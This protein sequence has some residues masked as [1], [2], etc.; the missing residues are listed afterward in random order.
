MQYMDKGPL[1]YFSNY[2]GAM[3]AD[4]NGNPRSSPNIDTDYRIGHT[5]TLEK[6]IYYPVTDGKPMAETELHRDVLIEALQTLFEYYKDAPDVCVSGNMMM[7]Y[8]KGEPRKSISPDVFVTFGIEKKLRRIY[9][10]WEEGKPPDFVI[11]FSS[12]NTYRNDLNAKKDLYASIGI[13]EYFLYDPERCHLPSPLM[14]FRLVEGE[15]VTISPDA[16]GNLYS[17]SLGLSLCLRENDLGFYDPVAEKW[18]ETP[19]DAARSIA[20][21]A[22]TRADQEAARAEKETAARQLVEAENARLQ[23]ELERLKALTTS[24]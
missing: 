18:L 24:S 3:M 5:P 14:G 20:E 21:E 12:E 9:K 10:I 7:Y 16:D 15:Y 8:V 22:Q 1:Y 23:K 13:T 4:K 11:E 19:A 17:E 2:G 6:D